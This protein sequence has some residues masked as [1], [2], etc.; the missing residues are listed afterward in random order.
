MF[1]VRNG[2]VLTLEG[3]VLSVTVKLLLFKRSGNAQQHQLCGF[4]DA[5]TQFHC[6][7]S[8]IEH[9]KGDGRI[10]ARVD[11]WSSHMN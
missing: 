7:F 1:F 6:N 4:I 11:L 5:S 10:E 3:V 9:L 8:E 2:R